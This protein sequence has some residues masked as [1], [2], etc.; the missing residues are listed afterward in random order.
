MPL[1]M[2]GPARWNRE[3]HYRR[4]LSNSG[5][6]IPICVQDF[7]YPDYDPSRFVDLADF[8]TEQE[9]AF[10]PLR[11]QDVIDTAANVIDTAA[12]T[13]DDHVAAGQAVR[14]LAAIG[15]HWSAS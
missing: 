8:P 3:V 1:D 15:S 12:N 13:P 11:P 14:L 5:S 7:D 9:A 2:T 6:V 4:Y 10:A